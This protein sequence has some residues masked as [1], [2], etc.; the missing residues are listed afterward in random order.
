MSQ[1]DS[2]KIQRMT[3]L[4]CLHLLHGFTARGDMT[5]TEIEARVR[6]AVGDVVFDEVRGRII[7]GDY[8]DVGTDQWAD[9]YPR[10][11]VALREGHDVPTLK[12]DAS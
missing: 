11:A 8:P 5:P 6:T 4:R 3:L 12:G 2:E 7:D 1:T 9:W 10:A